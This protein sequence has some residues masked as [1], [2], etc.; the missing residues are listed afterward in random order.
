M[1]KIFNKFF[2]QRKKYFFNKHTSPV[3]SIK[4]SVSEV[5]NELDGHLDAI[6]EN[7]NEI[8]LSYDCMNDLSNKIDNV[9]HR[10][11]KIELFLQSTKKYEVEEEVFEVKPLTKTEQHVFMVIYALEDEKG[12]VSMSNLCRKCGLPAYVVRDH[13]A[14]I[15]S[16]G[17][18]VMR[19]YIGNIQYLKLNSDF[20]RVQAKENLLM[21]DTA[22]KELVNF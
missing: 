19:Q 5:R 7:T 14:S 11:E 13:V 22:Q 4:N 9:A 16:K 6:N 18:P 3:D 8:Q 20:K 10:L 21:I 17:V 12:M 15:I 1:V 2:G